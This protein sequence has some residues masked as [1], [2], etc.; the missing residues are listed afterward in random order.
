MLLWQHFIRMD[1]ISINVY[2]KKAE[3]TFGNYIFIF[4]I[5]LPV[6]FLSEQ[7]W[8]EK[9][10]AKHAEVIYVKPLSTDY[11][12]LATHSW[13]MHLQSTFQLNEN[14]QRKKCNIFP[15]DL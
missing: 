15:E 11:L 12:R 5:S 8:W 4:Y 7:L 13:K 2:F 9:F 3:T 14:V 10:V 6:P 1:V